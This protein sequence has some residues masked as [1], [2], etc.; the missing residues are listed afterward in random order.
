MADIIMILLAALVV[1]LMVVAL[2]A[3]HGR[4]S[5]EARA[6]ELEERNEYLERRITHHDD[7]R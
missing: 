4:S 6:E 7:K 1:L 3:V 2:E 5:A